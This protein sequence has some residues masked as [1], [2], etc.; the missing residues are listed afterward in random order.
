MT[1]CDWFIQNIYSNIFTIVTVVFSS[2]ISLVISATYFHIGN[3]NNLKI[4]IV[5]PI[6]R[7]LEGHYTMKNYKKLCKMSEEYSAKYFKITEKKILFSMLN[8][9]K[10]VCNYNSTEVYAKILF[11]YFLD[12]LKENNID[13]N[14]Y[15]VEVDYNV[16]AYG[17]PV[18][19][20]YLEDEIE[21]VLNR[22]DPDFE[23]DECEKSVI[24]LYHYYC[25]KYYTNEKISYFHDC[26]L[27][28]VIKQ[29]EI[30]K[31]WDKKFDKMEKA[32]EEFLDLKIA[33]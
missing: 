13:V 18:D 11:L 15:P 31:E 20:M 7:I 9:Y 6:K 4:S 30:T 10:D 25:D 17:Y 27:R 19:L 21:K 1:F 29:S 22:F 8:A 32:K 5:Y 23:A 24:N 14:C 33:Q 12:K 28:K 26:S 3:R 16:V 2:I